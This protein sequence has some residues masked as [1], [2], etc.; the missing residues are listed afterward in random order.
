MANERIFGNLQAHRD[1]LCINV[2]HVALCVLE[3]NRKFKFPADTKLKLE[4]KKNTYAPRLSRLE[5]ST[6]FFFF[7]LTSLLKTER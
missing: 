2:S 5:S 3:N 4:R 6:I 1:D 7:L